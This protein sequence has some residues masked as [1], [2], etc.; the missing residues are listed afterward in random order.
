MTLAPAESVN[1]IVVIAI[2]GASEKCKTRNAGEDE[3]TSRFAGSLRRRRAWARAVAGKHRMARKKATAMPRA[4]FILV[5]Y[6]ILLAI[7]MFMPGIPGIALVF[8]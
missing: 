4:F 2:S 7:Y 6:A 5:W 1:T 3:S 8:F